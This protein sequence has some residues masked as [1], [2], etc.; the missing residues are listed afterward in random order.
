MN[1]SKEVRNKEPC[2]TNQNGLKKRIFTKKSTSIFM[3]IPN[4]NMSKIDKYINLLK[5]IN[6]LKYILVG[7]HDGPT[8]EHYHIYA[9]YNSTHTFHASDFD[10]AHI[11][12]IKSPIATM[13]YIKCQDKKHIKKRVQGD[14]YLEEGEPPH[15]G[16]KTLRELMK[17]SNEERKDL[18]PCQLLSLIKCESIIKE[19]E[20]IDK[21]L[22]VQNLIVE[23][24]TGEPGTGKTYYAKQEGKKYRLKN[25][26]VCVIE[27]DKNGFAH[28]LGNDTAQLLI[29]NEFRDSCM[30]FTDF[31]EITSNEHQYNSKHGGFYMPNLQKIIIT[32][33]QKPNEIYKNIHENRQQIYRRITKIY[34]HYKINN[35]YS[36]KEIN[37]SNN[38]DNH[39][40]NHDNLFCELNK[41]HAQHILDTIN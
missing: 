31:L 27:Y 33:I 3:T 10:N 29:L 23:W 16:R 5:S 24:H 14:I 2:N 20:M 36:M 1:K 38:N 30:K 26:D 6:G 12:E 40:S 32:S 8:L 19:S 7:K 17:L 4:E 9:Q 15:Q 11:K 28:K 34:E 37:I 21:W 13:K 22:E 18:P 35:K 41:E 25:L 39:E